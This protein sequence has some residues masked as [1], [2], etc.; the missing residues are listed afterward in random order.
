MPESARR[1]PT[2]LSIPK[3]DERF[4]VGPAVVDFWRWALGDLRMNT[5]RGFL[6]EFLV[7]GAVRSKAPIRVEWAS[8][9]VDGEDG[10][11]LEVKACG[12]LQSWAQAESRPPSYRFRSVRATRIWDESLGDYR[13]VDPQNRVDA[14]VFALQT[15]RDPEAYDVLDIDQWE[16]RVVPHRQLLASGQTSAGLSFFERLGIEPVKF[17][18]LADAVRSACRANEALGLG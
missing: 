5:A 16:F 6:A 3:A 12:Y 11:R 15:C 18:D 17:E 4:S 2:E 13:E 8:H 14:W 1:P 10:S 9:D 7:A